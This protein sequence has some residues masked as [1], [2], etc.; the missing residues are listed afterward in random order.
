MQPFLPCEMPVVVNHAGRGCWCHHDEQEGHSIP[1]L[2]HVVG[3]GGAELGV[4]E[5]V[6]QQEL[7]LPRFCGCAARREGGAQSP[8]PL[9]CAEAPQSPG[10]SYLG[11]APY[12]IH[13][14]SPGSRGLC[15]LY[16]Q[17]Q[18]SSAASLS[19]SLKDREGRAWVLQ[20][21]PRI[22]R[23]PLRLC[24]HG[25]R[26]FPSVLPDLLV[27]VLRCSP[28]LLTLPSLHSPALIT[29]WR[30]LEA[31][32]GAAHPA[33]RVCA[34]PVECC[35]AT[36]HQQEGEMLSA[37]HEQKDESLP[38]GKAEHPPSCGKDTSCSRTFWGK[39]SF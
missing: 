8:P 3:L 36:I 31:A 37:P 19:L 23:C 24:C 14:A 2:G 30:M 39:A 15:C 18:S 5:P 29:L 6:L 34:S 20:E 11:R 10:A 7:C 1:V 35:C 33:A 16:N 25:G 32:A 38:F 9:L 12:N 22:L 4:P 21:E 27:L 13:G 26:F 17:G 28:P